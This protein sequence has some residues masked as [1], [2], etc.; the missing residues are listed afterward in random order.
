MQTEEVATV[1]PGRMFTTGLPHLLIGLVWS[2]GPIV[3][4]AADA[5]DVQ[6]DS[7]VI[8]VVVVLWPLG[9]PILLCGVA[10][11]QQAMGERGHFR[12]GP[13]GIE[14]RL[15]A[16]SLYARL[17]G[18]I[19]QIRALPANPDTFAIRF[20]E[21]GAH[22]DANGYVYRFR[23]R[24]IASFEVSMFALVIELRSGAR[25]LLRRFYF[26]QHPVPIGRRL[27]EITQRLRAA[28]PLP[29]A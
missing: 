7:R 27:N 20:P 28:H 6:V 4:F 19:P 21:A 12:A 1:S 2:I 10:L 14:L 17:I 22:W 5:G 29:G 13:E 23:W 15:G 26:I 24:E 9:I 25:M 16:P 11:L 3:R 8:A 18:I